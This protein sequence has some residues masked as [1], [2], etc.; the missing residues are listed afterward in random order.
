MNTQI[1][2]FFLND[3]FNDHN[4]KYE[5]LFNDKENIQCDNLFKETIYPYKN[6]DKLTSNE[7]LFNVSEGFEK[8][9]L[10]KNLYSPYK[11][12]LPRKLKP[13]NEEQELLLKIDELSFAMFEIKLYL[14]N[15]PYDSNMIN[16]YNMLLKE[17]KRLLNRYQSKYLPIDASNPYM[18]NIP[19]SWKEEP[20]PWDRRIL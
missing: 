12:Y 16:N 2:E 18:V 9:N 3:N 7:N 14:N 15:F 10:F 5:D 6:E 11:N 8:G 13:E 20:W 1:Y 4:I 19:F 17:Q